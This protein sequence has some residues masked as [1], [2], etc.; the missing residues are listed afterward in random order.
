LRAYRIDDQWRIFRADLEAYDANRYSRL[1]HSDFKDGPIF[2]ESKG[3]ISVEKA[4]QMVNVPIQKIYYACRTGLLK[5]TRKRSS[6]VIN[7]EDL[8]RYEI[9]YLKKGIRKGA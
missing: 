4:A 1:L 3:I 5:A 9:D 8:L 7:V 2:D 6:W